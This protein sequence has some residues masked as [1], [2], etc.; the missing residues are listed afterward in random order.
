MKRIFILMLC[1]LMLICIAGCGTA[2]TA[3]GT[4]S[5]Q[6]QEPVKLKT[7]KEISTALKN[8]GLPIGTVVVFTAETDSNKLLGR[9]HQY[10]SKVGFADTTIEQSD[11]SDPKGGS[12]E[13]FSSSSD[14]KARKEYIDS[15]GKQSPM[16]I[17]Y[18]Y[19]NGTALL[20]LNSDLTPEQ[21]AKYEKGF[22]EL[23]I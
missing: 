16:F 17:E 5:T 4:S 3:E 6:N 10:I 13:F 15:F 20:R 8:K 23:D 22:K 9:P 12:V 18:S 2:K 21:A 19:I 1:I 7:A 14:T 11:Q